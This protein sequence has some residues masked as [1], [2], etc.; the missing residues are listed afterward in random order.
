MILE[1][2]FEMDMSIVKAECEMDDMVMDMG[3]MQEEGTNKTDY[4]QMDISK[5][6]LELEAILM[7]IDHLVPEFAD[8]ETQCNLLTSVE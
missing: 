8:K 7:E 6:E 2:E 3:L 1:D 4:T 5:E